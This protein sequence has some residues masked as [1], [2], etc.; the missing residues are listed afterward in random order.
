[1]QLFDDDDGVDCATVENA[2]DE[3]NQESS[4]WCGITLWQLAA[5]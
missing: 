5:L 4:S 2:A 1:M 3:S